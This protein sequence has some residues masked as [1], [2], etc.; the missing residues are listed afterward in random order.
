MIPLTLRATHPEKQQSVL[1]WVSYLK[2]LPDYRKYTLP[3]DISTEGCKAGIWV[4]FAQ[5]IEAIEAKV[6]A[7]KK[8]EDLLASKDFLVMYKHPAFY[9][10]QAIDYISNPAYTEQQK[11]VALYALE[12]LDIE[13]YIKCIETCCKL[14]TQNKLS[15][16]LLQTVVCF[17]FLRYH[18]IVYLYKTA[19]V[20]RCLENVCAMANVPPA[21]VVKINRI[22]S[23]EIRATWVKKGDPRMN[24]PSCLHD[25]N[26]PF[27]LSDIMVRAQQEFVRYIQN[28]DWEDPSDADTL[29]DFIV[30][31]DH[32][33]YYTSIGIEGTEDSAHQF[34]TKHQ[35]SESERRLAIFAMHQLHAQ[36]YAGLFRDACAMY[37]TGVIS[38]QMIEDLFKCFY[39]IRYNLQYPFFILDYKNPYLQC[40]LD[41]LIAIPTI[42]CGLKE[43]ARKV[44]K[45]TLATKEEIAYMEGYRTFRKTHFTLYE[46]IPPPE[47]GVAAV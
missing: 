28:V 15:T 33:M 40:A 37:R 5:K 13:Q 8:P 22:L 2:T 26:Y 1:N 23:G 45:G 12:L 38:P 36:P 24:E 39:P 7:W 16:S 30:V 47:L 41:E 21:L 17:E 42:P 35:F 4:T 34:I 10:Q 6:G 44:K 31:F 20:V 14:Y 46:T 43:M 25:Y 27:K 9:W 32:P 18:P 3:V 29:S 19:P 11:K